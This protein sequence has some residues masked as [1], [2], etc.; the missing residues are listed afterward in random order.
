MAP[1]I[2]LLA[3]PRQRGVHPYQRHGL[4]YFICGNPGL[5]NYYAVFLDCLRGMLDAEDE[6][7]GGTAYDIY[8]RNL[9]GFSD[10]DHEPFSASNEP[11]DLDGQIDGMFRDVASRT[12]IPDEAGA[13]GQEGEAARPYDFV[14]LMGHSV[15][16]Y[17]SVEIFHRHM[18]D[19][20]RA[21]HLNLRHGFLLFPTLTHIANSPKGRN[22]G[23]LM[24]IPGLENNAQHLA[25][26]ILNCIPYA[27]VLWIIKNVLGFTPQTAE[28]TARWL[29]SQ[30]GVWQAIHLGLSEM[31]T[32]CE[33][34]WE[35]ELWETTA[36]D[37]DIN[38]YNYYQGKSKIS[39]N[40][41]PQGG[42]ETPQQQIPKF[43][44]FYGKNDHWV[45]NHVRD[46]F[47]EKR[48]SEKGHTKIQVDE[49]DIP[50][51][52]CVKEHTS[53]VIAKRVYE[54]VKEIE[55]GQQTL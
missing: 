24:S 37:D 5:V 4:I 52:F 31:R 17:I 44:I 16:A 43:F 7:S 3:K 12:V 10:D 26:F 39:A 45:A 32:I 25:K 30:G 35:E 47:I 38:S 46:A 54:W 53:W 40:G 2:S 11:W 36:E 6:G 19:P 48:K 20:S 33:E 55:D 22:V 51:A 27:F 50:H 23:L 28:V 15:G 42:A 29:K 14:V 34:K 8:G 18:Q 41:E 49:G 9:L 1:A 13:E 21:P